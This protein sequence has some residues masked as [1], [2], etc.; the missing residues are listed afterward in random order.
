M[1]ASAPCSW[2]MR[3]KD[4]ARCVP[5]AETPATTGTRPRVSLTTVSIRND[6]FC[7]F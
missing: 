1:S 3:V 7:L 5:E 2:A 4:V 6:C